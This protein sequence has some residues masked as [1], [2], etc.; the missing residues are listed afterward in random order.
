MHL[1]QFLDA[2]VSKAIRKLNSGDISS[3][4]KI[5]DE[6][7]SRDADNFEAK[8]LGAMIGL[9][10]D[11][12]EIAVI[13]LESALRTKPKFETSGFKN[14]FGKSYKDLANYLENATLKLIEIQMKK[15]QNDEQAVKI[16]LIYTFYL[17]LA[18]HIQKRFKE[19]RELYLKCL[20]HSD[21]MKS[22]A[23]QIIN[24]L[25]CL[26]E[27]L[28]SEDEARKWIALDTYPLVFEAESPIAGK[29]VKE[30]NQGLYAEIIASQKYQSWPEIQSDNWFIGSNLNSDDPGPFVRKLEKIFME[31]A[32]RVMDQVEVTSP[33]PGHSAFGRRPR[34][35]KVE[36]F[37]SG[38]KGG[39]HVGPHVHSDAFMT[40][41]YYVKVPEVE[42]AENN[43]LGCVEYGK[44]LYHAAIGCEKKLRIIR[45]FEGL[46]LA[47]PSYVSHST[48]P[49]GTD[50][51]RMVVGYDIVP[52]AEK[53]I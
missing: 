31:R 41:N 15:N 2:K 17:G 12:L 11:K 44:S 16:P 53:K 8:I 29:S 10:A 21:E 19:A 45:P 26:E 20:S 7:A 18:L 42:N 23:G 6:I 14:K 47:W 38:L 4:A 37:A 51:S 49:C 48:I 32:E 28:G 30:F 52:V 5:Y 27:Q 9:L 3:A 50:Q 36:M 13:L 35:F 25:A 1:A 24:L 39:G 46:M 22:W 40:G 33:V 43:D 34:K